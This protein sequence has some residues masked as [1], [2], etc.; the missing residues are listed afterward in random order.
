M[1][2]GSLEVTSSVV[3][4]SL[5]LGT[6]LKLAPELLTKIK[7]TGTLYFFVISGLHFAI[8]EE[9]LVVFFKPLRLS[10]TLR[11]TLVGVVLLIFGGVVGFSIPILRTL[12]MY[13]YRLLGVYTK[14]RL[15]KKVVFLWMIAVVICAAPFQEHPTLLSISFLLSFGAVFALLFFNS[16]QVGTSLGSQFIQQLRAGVNVNMCIAPLLIYFFGTWNPLSIFFSL[17]FSPFV[18]MLVWI[19]FLFLAWETVSFGLF[20]YFQPISL[21]VSGAFSFVVHVFSLLLEFCETISFA[22]SLQL[23]PTSLCIYY[24]LICFVLIL[25]GR[26]RKNYET[27]FL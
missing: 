6:D 8:L 16:S 1:S 25:G 23:T 18:S 13:W 24:F 9:I 10:K 22:V 2:K 4:S 27:N 15:A 11:L 21:L 7:T 14:K 17:L 26:I 12:V 19:G 5:L 3:L 20:P